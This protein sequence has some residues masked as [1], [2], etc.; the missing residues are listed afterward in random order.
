[1]LKKGGYEVEVC[2][3]H[4]LAEARKNEPSFNLVILALSGNNKLTEA[5]TYGERLKKNNP[6]LP[7]LLLLDVN[8]F[9][10]G[11]IFRHSV[12]SGHPEELMNT[13]ATMLAEGA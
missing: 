8:V 10:S 11:G 12:V 2:D 13:V 9:L 1:L 6:T 4:S 3:N 5:R 7:L